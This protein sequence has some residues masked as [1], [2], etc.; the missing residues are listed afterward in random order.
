MSA[1]DRAQLHG[2]VR[3]PTRGLSKEWLEVIEAVARSGRTFSPAFF[4]RNSI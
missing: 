2:I 1:L 3:N 4:L